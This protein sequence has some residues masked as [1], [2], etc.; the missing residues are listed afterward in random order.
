MLKTV[1]VPSIKGEI[2]GKNA[3]AI[4]EKENEFLCKS[5]ASTTPIVW[6][7]AFGSTIV[8]VDDNRF[9]DFTSGILVANVGHS[10]PKVVKAIQEQAGKFLNSYNA[11]HELRSR[12]SEKLVKLTPK[13]LDRAWLLTTGA[14][15]VESGIK[16]AKAYTG[17]NEIISFNGSF[18]GKTHLT[19][20]V[21][22]IRDTK[23]GFGPQAS[24]IIHAPFPYMYRSY[25]QDEETAVDSCLQYLNDIMNTST[26][27]SIA[28]VVMESYHGGGGCVVPPVRFVQG[29][30]KLCDKYN[31]LFIIDEVQAGFGRTGKM[32]GFQHY[33]VVP[34]IVCIAKGLASGV[35]TSAVIAKKNVMDALPA[36]SATT[37][38]GGNPLSCAAALA[39][40]DVMESEGLV[41][42]AS[43]LGKVM[44]KRLDQL[45]K[46][47]AFLGEARSIG[48]VTGLEIVEDPKTRIPSVEIAK[49][50]VNESIKRG[51]ALITP[52]GI[53]GNVIRMMPPLVITEEDLNK[54]LDILDNAMDAVLAKQNK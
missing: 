11:A 51:L 10:H 39:V 5:S 44:R 37:T 49:D 21:G 25:H 46:K 8:D 24:N 18:H 40:I 26:S 12:L 4:L 30:R 41:Q 33:E 32:F 48:M 34:D 31:I 20:G 45:E 15:A 1:P 47:Y 42:R 53:H 2:P 19:M 13:G 50:I 36:G 7:E 23:E 28:A 54:G 52:T 9:I 16:M 3:Q 6:K 22:G 17:K 43:E 29:I 27:G 35:P 14:E 38:Y